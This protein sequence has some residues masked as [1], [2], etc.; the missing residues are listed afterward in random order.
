MRCLCRHSFS[1]SLWSS[2]WLAFSLDL[3]IG[4]SLLSILGRLF[5]SAI[6]ALACLLGQ[7]QPLFFGL[8]LHTGDTLLR[9]LLRGGR[10][11]GRRFRRLFSHWRRRRRRCSLDHGL[12]RGFTGLQELAATLHLNRDLI[13]AAMAKGLLDL[14]SIDRTFQAQRL[15][16]WFFLFVA[17][18]GSLILTNI[19][20]RP[21]NPHVFATGPYNLRVSRGPLA[22]YRPALYRLAPYRFYPLR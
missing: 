16:G 22:P 11:F 19:L 13:R 20:F 17:H 3:F 21:A 8:A 12:R 4:R 2:F 1:Y 15:A 10:L 9:G 18:S 7:A 5:R 14:A 6:V